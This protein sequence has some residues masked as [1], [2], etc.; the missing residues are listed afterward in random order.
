[1]KPNPTKLAIENEHER[2]KRI[3]FYEEPHIYEVDGK[4]GYTSVTTFIGS[5]FDHFNPDAIID[6]IIKSGKLQDPDYKYY[7]MSRE[8]IKAQWAA[9]GKAS[10]ESGTITHFNIECYYN[11]IE[12]EDDSIEYKYFK[13]FVRDHAHLEAYRTEMYI[14]DEDLKLSGSIDMLFRDKNTGDFYIYDWKRTKDII[15]DTLYNKRAK[16]KC[17]NHLPDTNFWH[18]ALQLNLYARILKDK[19]D[20]E[21]KKLCLVVL[22]PDNYT[23]DYILFPLPFLER[24]ITDLFEYRKDQLKEIAS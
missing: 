18:Y 6:K 5:H 14:F 20:I 17:V 7:N 2:D 9:N 1:M 15:E 11:D 10:A 4:Q 16:T 12:Q 21:I 19:Y 8:E 13:N 23:N 22:H 24:E 3:V